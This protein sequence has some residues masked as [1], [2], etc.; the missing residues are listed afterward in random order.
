MRSYINQESDG[1]RELLQPI[2]LLLQSV[3]CPVAST[4]AL[5]NAP[6]AQRV[7]KFNRTLNGPPTVAERMPQ[8][9]GCL[10]LGLRYGSSMEP[11]RLWQQFRYGWVTP[12]VAETKI[13]R[14]M[15]TQDVAI[16]YTRTAHVRYTRN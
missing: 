13:L 14:M 9:M 7:K 15:R 8:T 4:C 11:S 16:W 3:T 1:N 12:P 2:L 5:H 10:P 6:T